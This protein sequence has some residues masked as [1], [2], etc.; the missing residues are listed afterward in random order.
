[1]RDYYCRG[2]VL[3]NGLLLT[4]LYAGLWTSPVFSSDKLTIAREGKTQYVVVQADQATNSEKLAIRELTTF[5]SRVTGASF[6]VVTESALSGNV[7]GIYVGWTKYMAA[8]GI[9]GAK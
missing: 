8:S 2:F 1:M 7:R 9:E 5:L 3:T 4:C 6:P